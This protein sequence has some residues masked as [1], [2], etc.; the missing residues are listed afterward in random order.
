[1]HQSIGKVKTADY[2]KQKEHPIQLDHYI[3]IGM[4]SLRPFHSSRHRELVA[5]GGTYMDCPRFGIA[6]TGIHPYL[7]ALNRKRAGGLCF[8]AFVSPISL[9]HPCIFGF[10]ND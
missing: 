1:L 9:L 2:E 4:Y 7:P 8:A 3:I 5:S 6:Y 10:V